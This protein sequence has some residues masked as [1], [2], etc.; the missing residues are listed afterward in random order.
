[1]YF[2]DSFSVVTGLGWVC[3]RGFCLRLGGVRCFF[4]TYV[5]FFLFDS[6]V[7]LVLRVG[8]GSVGRVFFFRVFCIYGGCFWGFFCFGVLFGS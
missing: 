4:C 1:M 5:F 3:L 7:F 8:I 2:S 6:Y